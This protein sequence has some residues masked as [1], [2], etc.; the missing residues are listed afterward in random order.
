MVLILEAMG[1]KLLIN[2]KATPTTINARTMFIN[3]ISFTLL[4]ELQKATYCY[5]TETSAP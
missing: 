3:G 5:L 1:M 2:H 4:T